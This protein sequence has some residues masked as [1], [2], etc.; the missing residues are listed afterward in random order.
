MATDAGGQIK[1]YA[2]ATSVNKGGSINFFVSREP[3]PDLHHRHLSDGLVPGAGWATHAAHRPARRNSATD[4]PD[5]RHDRADRVQLAPRLHPADPDDLDDRHLPGGHQERSRLR[6]RDHLRGPRRQP[7]RRNS[8]TSSR[9]TPIRPTTTTRPTARRARASTSSTA[10]AR[11]RSRGATAG[12]KGLVRPSLH[13]SR[14]RPFL[15]WD[16]N[17]VRWL[18]RSGYDVSYT[19]DVDT[20]ENGSRLLAYRGF[21]SVGPRRILVQADVRRSVGGARTRA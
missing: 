3:V 6:Q 13:R 17:L 7:S 14:L 15:S 2:S 9:S 20:H 16:V 10:T 18:E 1:G 21:L 5:G 4:L 12:G 19:T 11:R 8:S